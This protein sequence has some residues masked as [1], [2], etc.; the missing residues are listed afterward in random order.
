MMNYESDEIAL[1]TN[2]HG[3][4]I[5]VCVLIALELVFG[6]RPKFS[7]VGVC[8]RE[9]HFSLRW[10][11]LSYLLSWQ[12]HDDAR[13]SPIRPLHL[14]QFLKCFR[15]CALSEKC[16]YQ[17]CSALIYFHLHETHSASILWRQ[18]FWRPKNFI[19]TMNV[20]RQRKTH[21]HNRTR[22]N[23]IEWMLERSAKRND[24][25]QTMDASTSLTA[26]FPPNWR[27]RKNRTKRNKRE[28]YCV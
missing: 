19:I 23:W 10:S 28:K 21:R 15:K 3:T 9:S 1:R 11:F 4:H 8:A 24:N 27:R 18:M 22:I 16:R 7:F 13:T 20:K 5:R 26:S 2:G 14:H 17:F 6:S 12:I 25:E